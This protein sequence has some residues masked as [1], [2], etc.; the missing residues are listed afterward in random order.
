MAVAVMGSELAIIQPSGSVNA[1]NVLEFEHQL[2]TAILS[3]KHSGLLVDLY[4]VEFLDSAGLLA[5][6]SAFRLAQL[7]Q[8]RFS[9]C[10]VTP[11]IRMIFELTQLDR[12]FEIF[13]NRDACMAA[14]N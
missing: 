7:Q 1:S 2:T 11:A 10:S 8:R 9:L 5:L 13:E 4:R 14:M 12:A 3:D 6:V